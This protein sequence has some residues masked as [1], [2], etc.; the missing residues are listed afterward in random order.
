[1][2]IVSLWTISE[3][4]RSINRETDVNWVFCGQNLNY[5]NFVRYVFFHS[6]YKHILDIK[7][8][9]I[10]IQDVVRI[11]Y[12]VFITKKL[13][14]GAY[15]SKFFFCWLQLQTIDRNHS[16]TPWDTDISIC[17]I[18]CGGSFV[19]CSLLKIAKCK[20]LPLL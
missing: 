7:E 10:K 11:Q 5:R 1:M 6:K 4:C 19:S 18:L 2:V 3:S 17:V 8:D 12:T 15:F 16:G 9:V 14:D 13:F 20:R